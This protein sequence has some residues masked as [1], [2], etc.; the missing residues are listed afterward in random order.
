MPIKTLPSPGLLTD[1][2]T[3]KLGVRVELV[4]EGAAKNF[5]AEQILDLDFGSYADLD[6]AD[7]Q[8]VEFKLVSENTT[9][10]TSDVQIYFRD[11]NQ[12]VVDSLF[13]GGAKPIME[14]APVNAAGITTGVKRT[15]NYIPMSKARFDQI[16]KTKTAELKTFF[17]TANGGTQFVKLLADNN[18]TVKMGMKVKV[19]R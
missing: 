12:R 14:A 16:R 13:V 9:P 1:N 2:S 15:E 7:I 5:G 8:E 18:V 4:L 10:I 17:T 3:I 19:K 11:E 6:S